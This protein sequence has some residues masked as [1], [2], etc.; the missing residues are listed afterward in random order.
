MALRTPILP[1]FLGSLAI[2]VLSTTAACKRPHPEQACEPR[3][4]ARTHSADVPPPTSARS[5]TIETVDVPDDRKVLVVIGDG[6]RPIIY[7]HGMCGEARS[8]LEAWASGV[9]EHGTI[10]A[11]EGDAACPN[12]AGRTWSADPAALDARIGAAIEAVAS[13]RGVPLDPNDIILIGESLGATRATA[14]AK[15]FPE[16]YRRLVLVGGPETP[17][18]RD[19]RSASAVA[20]L[21]GEHEPQE[22]MRRGATGLENAGLAARFWELADATH[23][24]Y[25]TDGARSMGEAVAFVAGPPR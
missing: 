20:L 3:P 15:R 4:G 6:N 12:G 9:S 24:T 14:L 19:L 11:L 10:I 5:G 7:L 16:R 22:K 23:G 18:A 8:D 17:S 25:G 21:A 1:G 2:V 13:A